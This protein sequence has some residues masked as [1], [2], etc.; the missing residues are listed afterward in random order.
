MYSHHVVL[1]AFDEKLFLSPLENPQ[2]ILD[3]GTGSGIWAM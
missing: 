3:I 1:L 2:K